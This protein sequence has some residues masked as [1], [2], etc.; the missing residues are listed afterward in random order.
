MAER[1]RDDIHFLAV[2]IR[3]AHPEEAWIITENR[4]SGL[5]VHE[6]ETED[7]R[8][9]VASDC[10]V[11]LRMKMPIVVDGLDNA[12]ASEYG[13]WPDRLYLVRRDGRIAF[14]G[15][16]GRFGFKPRELEHAIERE[17][18]QG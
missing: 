14:Q 10:A 2:Y 12:V 13:G 15:G 8:R 18:A 16:E 17:L 9:A 4:R 11:N 7:A 3:E 6:P 1:H 5:A